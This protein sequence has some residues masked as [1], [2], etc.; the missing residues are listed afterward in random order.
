MDTIVTRHAISQRS[1]PAPTAHSLA[2]SDPAYRRAAEAAIA[3]RDHHDPQVAHRAARA[4]TA[5]YQAAVAR[6]RA[7]LAGR[8]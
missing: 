8:R 1:C 7:S 2:H 3:V 4:A 5:A 6:A